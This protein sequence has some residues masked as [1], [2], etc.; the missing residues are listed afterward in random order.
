VEECQFHIGWNFDKLKVKVARVASAF[1]LEILHCT[2]VLLGLLAR[3]EGAQIVALACLRIFL[4][5]VET[6]FARL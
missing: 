6:V 3:I 2:L 1:M 4:T 5:R